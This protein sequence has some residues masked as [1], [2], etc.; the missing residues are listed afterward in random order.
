MG[1]LRVAGEPATVERPAAEEEAQA[2]GP[3]ANLDA[4]YRVPSAMDTLQTLH[5]QVLLHDEDT[6]TGRDGEL[7]NLRE[8]L[9]NGGTAALTRAGAKG[10][11]DETTLSGMGGIGKTA[12]TCVCTYSNVTSEMIPI[13]L[14]AGADPNQRSNNNKGLPVLIS[15]IR[16]DNPRDF[17]KLKAVSDSTK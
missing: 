15:A 14:K 7:K 13:L 9:W 6:F 2:L 16:N 10:L 5:T 3:A 11:V 4:A 1:P 8:M 17:D 12:L